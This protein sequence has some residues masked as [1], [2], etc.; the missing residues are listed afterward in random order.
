[1]TEDA[2]ISVAYTVFKFSWLRSSPLPF[3]KSSFCELLVK[4]KN[5]GLPLSHKKFKNKKSWDPFLGDLNVKQMKPSSLFSA[6]V[7]FEH[8]CLRS[9]LSTRHKCDIQRTLFLQSPLFSNYA[10]WSRK[11]ENCCHHLTFSSV[12]PFVEKLQKMEENYTIR[13]FHFLVLVD[14]ASFPLSSCEA[15]FEDSCMNQSIITIGNTVILN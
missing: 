15:A 8:S 10:L 11:G 14:M 4:T 2:A 6:Y 5:Q 13:L 7:Q 12:I 3:R 1:M 9:N